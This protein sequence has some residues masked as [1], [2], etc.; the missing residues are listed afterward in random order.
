MIYI[1]KHKNIPVAKI[2]INKTG[3]I[4]EIIEKYDTTHASIEATAN[5]ILNKTSLN[6]WYQNR[7]IPDN[8]YNSIKDILLNKGI[9]KADIMQKSFGLNLTDQYWICPKDRNI[10]WEHINFFHNKFY[11]TFSN[12]FF[13]PDKNKI[14]DIT[15]TVSPDANTDGV[16]NKQWIQEDG[17]QYLIKSGTN[18]HHQESYNEVIASFLMKTLDIE[19]VEYKLC[20]KFKV[21]TCICKNFITEDTEFIPAHA[22][23]SSISKPNNVSNYEHYI[24]CLEALNIPNAREKTEQMI[25]ID[26]IMSNTDRHFGNFGIIRDA[27]TLRP[28]KLAPIFDTGTSLGCDKIAMILKNNYEVPAKPF[29]KTQNAQIKLVKSINWLDFSKTPQIIKGIEQILETAPMTQQR[30]ETIIN[31]IINKLDSLK[32]QK[33]LQKLPIMN[34]QKESDKGFEMEL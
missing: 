7:G 5:G 20:N 24:N 30:K 16:L 9:T 19:H 22:I 11:T 10:K 14:N 31:S 3:N 21:P 15:D 4:T 6:H 27:N 28:L 8:R 29:R 18:P 23:M 1:L 26:Y 2:K 32:E 17:T 13:N 34:F 12:A 25:V 33:T